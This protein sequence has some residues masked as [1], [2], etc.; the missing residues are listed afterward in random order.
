MGK[1]ILKLLLV[2]A[3][4]ASATSVVTLKFAQAT[5]PVGVTNTLIAGPVAL[6]EFDAVVHNEDFKA[7][8]KTQGV[9]DAYV[10]R[11]TIAPGGSTGWHSHPGIVFVLI[12]SGAVTLYDD[13]FN[14]TVFAAGTGFVEEPGH[15]HIAVN[16]GNSDLELVVF[17]LVP[18]G[19]GTRID[20]PAPE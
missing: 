3:L 7:R 12:R 11:L 10:S 17:F 8:I 16:E 9:A 15:V 1:R 20:E 14:R 13:E 19:A 2:G 4:I 6:D 18:K 5:P